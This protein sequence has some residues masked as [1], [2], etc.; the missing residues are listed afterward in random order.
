MLG[1]FSINT[2]TDKIWISVVSYEKAFLIFDFSTAG[3]LHCV[4]TEERL[5]VLHYSVDLIFL[6]FGIMHSIMEL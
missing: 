5:P 6:S 3:D 4:V 1:A 2:E